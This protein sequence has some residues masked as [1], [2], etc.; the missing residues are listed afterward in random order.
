MAPL[1]R[2]RAGPG[3]VPTDLNATYYGQ[4]ASAGLIIS[5]ATSV[6]ERGFGYADTPGIFSGAQASGWRKVTEAVHARAGRIFLQLWH[7]G[8]ISHPAFQPDGDRPVAPSAVRPRGKVQ[9]PGGPVDFVTPR[10]LEASEIP[11]LVDE[12]ARGARLAMEAGFDGVE[13]HN[14]NGYLLDQFLRDGTNHRTDGYGGSARKRARLTLEVVEAVT[15]VCGCGRVGIRF[16][17]GGVF[18]DMHDS[19][20]LDTFGHVLRELRPLGLAYAHI[21]RTSAEDAQH[22]AVEI[23]PRELRPDYPGNIVSAGDFTLESGNQALAEGWADAVAFGGLFLANPDLPER[24]RAH[25]PLNSPNEATFY[26][27]G[28]EGYTDYPRLSAP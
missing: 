23:G 27:K 4:R 9:T 3:N 17:P 8:R 28:S 24:F 5:E 14:A 13:I 6:S 21:T 22:G 18:N 26:S 2:C 19:H 1:T 12:Y 7:V 11:L 10:A 20:P 15:G 25:A 16:S